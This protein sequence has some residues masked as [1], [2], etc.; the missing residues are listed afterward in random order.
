MILG[1]DEIGRTQ[2]GNNNAYCQD[3]EISWLDW[4]NVDKDLFEFTRRL[5]RIRAEHPVFRRRNWFLGRRIRGADLSDVGWFKPDGE[6]M[7]D[8][9][10][11]NGFGRSLGIYLNGDAI[12]MRGTRGE[13][14][15]D[16]S[17]YILFN[18][19][20]ERLDFALPHNSWGDRWQ[21]YLDT[22]DPQEPEARSE[23]PA[24]EKVQTKGRSVVVLRR[25]S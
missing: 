18:G 23:Y 24:G 7:S 9:D 10:W 20:H 22:A 5:I 2:G 17:F 12:T 25:I 14:I 16:D 8:E 21:R 19:H 4:S 1:G 15:E 11:A 6:Q 3:S 13:R